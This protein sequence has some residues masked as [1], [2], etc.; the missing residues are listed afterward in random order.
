MGKTSHLWEDLPPNCKQGLRS[1]Y[2]KSSQ[3]IKGVLCLLKEITDPVPFLI[4]TV[5]ESQ[6]FPSGT[7]HLSNGGLYLS[8]SNQF[9]FFYH[10]FS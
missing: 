9:T 2:L 1:Q 10:K 3:G 6:G 5:L 4:N 7:L 8:H